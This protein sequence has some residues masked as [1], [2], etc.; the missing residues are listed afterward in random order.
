MPDF[1]PFQ[2]SVNFN[3]NAAAGTTECGTVTL[4]DDVDLEI[5]EVF[6][7]NIKSGVP[8]YTLLDD[9]LAMVFIIDDDNGKIA[10]KSHHYFTSYGTSYTDDTTFFL[11]LYV[12]IALNMPT[13]IWALYDSATIVY[14]NGSC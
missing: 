5:R 3:S 14:Y 1:Q 7:A 6:R 12:A 13:N 11:C 8:V 2:I 10:V 9:N 4:V